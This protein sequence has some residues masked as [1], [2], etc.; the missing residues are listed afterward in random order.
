MINWLCKNIKNCLINGHFLNFFASF[1]SK[2]VIFFFQFVPFFDRL[3]LLCNFRLWTRTMI[4]IL[5]M[6]ITIAHFLYEPTVAANLY[7]PNIKKNIH[8]GNGFYCR[9]EENQGYH[10]S[11]LQ[12]TLGVI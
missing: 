3:L 8:Y 4:P 10:I 7:I 1:S 9:S 12:S 5:T 2:S 6:Q 11:I